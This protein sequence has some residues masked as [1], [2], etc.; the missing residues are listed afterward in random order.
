MLDTAKSGVQRILSNA[1]DYDTSVETIDLAKRYHPTILAAIGLHPSTI[2]NKPDFELTQF[3]RLL[4]EN[5]EQVKAIGEIGLDGKYT[6]D[7]EKR[8]RQREVFRHFLG[9][10][11]KRRLPVVV[12][13]RL[14]VDEV[15]DELSRFARLKVLLHWYDG[16]V[17]KLELIRERGYFISIGPASFYSKRI[18]EIALKADPGMILSETDGPVSYHGPF[19]G[20]TTQSSFVIDVVRRLA[21]IRSEKVETVRDTIWMNFQRYTQP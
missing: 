5:P 14:A 15:L 13:S 19:Q 12:H 17:E 4:D 9:I 1:V 8:S 7:Q 3:E 21:E 6:Q 11:D 18:L 16:P 10:A 20:K 2:V